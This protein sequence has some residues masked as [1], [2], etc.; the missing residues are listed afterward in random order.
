[1]F[2]PRVIPVLLLKDAGLVK[3]VKFKSPRYVGDPINAVKIF[4]DLEV[5]ELIFLD[6][7]ASKQGRCISSELVKDIGDEAYMPFAVGGGIKSIHEVQSLIQAGAEKVVINS[8]ALA[9]TNII[10][11]AAS[12]FGSQS[13]VAS[14]DVKK[15]LFGKYEVF[16]HVTEKTIKINLSEH[17]QK[18][19]DAGAGEL[20]INS[21]DA[22][23]TMKGYDLPL[24]ESI[25]RNI[26]VPLIACGGA[27]NLMHMKE[28]MNR[29]IADAVAAGS[30]FVF[31][32]P[33]NAV[34]IN[35]PER[36]QITEMLSR[37]DE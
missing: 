27:G 26:K 7:M 23:G 35:Y 24:Y 32:G 9:N 25:Y 37:N 30:M 5:D 10:T 3:T 19:V 15:S 16:N 6:I 36:I 1:M 18:L 28:I 2:R 22:D 4:N 11:E 13:V 31:Y 21:V 17:L 33:R 34:L 14:V 12:L 8:N 29:N 20:F